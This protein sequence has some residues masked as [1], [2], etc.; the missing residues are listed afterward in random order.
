MKLRSGGSSESSASIQPS[1]APSAP[2]SNA[3]RS[4]FFAVDVVAGVAI[5]EPRSSS[6]D[7]IVSSFFLVWLGVFGARCGPRRAALD[8]TTFTPRRPNNTQ[9]HTHLLRQRAVLGDGKRAR[10]ADHRVELVDVAER[11]KDGV[12]L[13]APLAVVQR[14]LA[15][16]AGARVDFEP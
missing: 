3:T 11:V 6:R 13:G 9:Q 12:V 16:V 8:K 5:A 7:W 15:A 14:R 1:K 4:S 2:A 10:R